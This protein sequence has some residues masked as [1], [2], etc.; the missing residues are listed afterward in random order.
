MTTTRLEAVNEILRGSRIL[1]VA[2]L[3][4]QSDVRTTLAESTLD[5]INR[6]VQGIGWSFNRREVTIVPDG[7]DNIVIPEE[8][9]LVE[10]QGIHERYAVRGGLLYDMCENTDEFSNDMT[11]NVIELLDWDDLPQAAKDYITAKASRVFA[12]RQI[13]DPDLMRALRQDEKET[14]QLLRRH[15]VIQGNRRI[16]D[17]S[18]GTLVDRGSP[19]NRYN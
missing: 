16:W 4:T 6:Q 11:I 5:Q 7:S 18:G 13:T 14:Y 1:P 19:V 8:Y 3:V 2:D 9:L 12:D 10:G 17:A 15:S